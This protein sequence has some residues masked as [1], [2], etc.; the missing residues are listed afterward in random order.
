MRD[1]AGVVADRRQR[2]ARSRGGF[3]Y[4]D[5]CA[6]L[7]VLRALAT[8]QLQR[9]EVELATDLVVHSVDGQLEYVSVKS[10]E[11]S[12]ARSVGWDWSAINGSHVL[13][14]LYRHWDAG[15]RCGS[16]TVWTNAGLRSAATALHGTH[17][18]SSLDATLV[19]AV[20]SS[21]EAADADARDFLA[22]FSWPVLPL[23]AP[24]EMDAVLHDE[25]RAYLRGRGL[26]PDG[27]VAAVAALVAAIAEAST[28]DERRVPHV[29]AAEQLRAGEDDLRQARMLTADRLRQVIEEA[30][31]AP[32]PA[33]LVVDRRTTPLVGRDDAMMALGR[34]WADGDKP[35]AVVHG[36]VG[37]GKSSV[38]FNWAFG[39]SAA[40][41]HLFDASSAAQVQDA[42]AVIRQDTA[43]CS[44]Q[45]LVVVDG[46]TDSAVW[47]RVTRLSLPCRVLATSTCA[48]TPSHDVAS[49]E[50]LELSDE[51]AGELV[52]G[53][54]ADDAGSDQLLALLGGNPLALTQAAAVCSLHH[55]TPGDYVARYRGQMA[56]ALAAGDVDDTLHALGIARQRRRTLA[57]ALGVHL[58]VV[59]EQQPDEY[60]LLKLIACCG[61]GSFATRRLVAKLRMM[62]TGDDVLTEADVRQERPSVAAWREGD[63]VAPLS[64]LAARSLVRLHDGSFQMHE[65]HRRLI[66]ARIPDATPHMEYL[67]GSFSAVDPTSGG[68]W[69]PMSPRIAR[70]ASSFIVQ[71]EELG[72]RGP[73]LYFVAAEAIEY[74][75]AQG[76]LEQ[77]EHLALLAQGWLQRTEG[78]VPA[79]Q[80]ASV[81]RSVC[82]WQLLSGRVDDAVPALRSLAGQSD[83]PEIALWATQRIAEI[84]TSVARPDLLPLARTLVPPPGADLSALPAHTASRVA[85]VQARLL[86]FDGYT[87]QALELLEQAVERCQREDPTANC[88]D[89]EELWSSLS[90]AVPPEVRIPRIRQ[91]LAR[92]EQREEAERTTRHLFILAALVEAYLDAE[93]WD[94]A[95][96]VLAQAEAQ[97]TQHHLGNLAVR[98]QLVQLRAR[99]LLDQARSPQDLVAAVERFD[100]AIAIGE[101][102]PSG[103]APYLAAAWFNKATALGYLCCFPQAHEAA[104]N[105]RALDE[106]R[107]GPDHEEVAI[108]QKLVEAIEVLM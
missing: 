5:Q 86:W 23:P 99:L 41:V 63:L 13:R 97:A 92:E 94:E 82:E 90:Y 98:G 7:G 25:A 65:A 67:L 48:P 37:V 91:W 50:L 33:S 103:E 93:R 77:A 6:A 30:A 64:R 73:G 54:V 69:I 28:V 60:E 76:H 10:R 85:L 45:D 4:Q 66:M 104:L 26:D 83:C 46:I 80:R 56:S 53:L 29:T 102:L 16:A 42:L 107:H 96:P 79:V 75:V 74:L 14:D 3:A 106:K 84:A 43:G 21:I 22:A 57:A 95:A 38:A 51:K 15:G 40:A 72:L 35:F 2:G 39:S 105:A 9:I 12:Q 17:D 32:A 1:R 49:V 11:P 58:D 108:D 20:A 8:G 27:E 100:E 101:G 47:Q 88:D 62:L 71:A 81:V 78:Q 68:A 89:L 34:W 19:T 31:S 44:P 36:P 24:H 61:H 59:R 18:P 70:E 52:R 55:I 87:P